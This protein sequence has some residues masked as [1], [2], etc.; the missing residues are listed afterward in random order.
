MKNRGVPS[1]WKGAIILAGLLTGGAALTN[2]GL[3]FR[4]N[5]IFFPEKVAVSE[6]TDGDT[7]NIKW[8]LPVRLVGIDAPNRGEDR[9]A[10]AKKGLEKLIGGRTVWL[11]YDRYPA[12][13]K[14]VRVLAWVWLGCEGN[15][16]F[17]PWNYMHKSNNESNPG[18]TENPEGCKKGKLAQEEMVKMRF[19]LIEVYKDRGELKYEKKLLDN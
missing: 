2:I 4:E 14:Y 18:L 16:K 11:E 19:A 10:E 3:N 7:F 17:L 8:G 12:D 6:V 13:E 5:K 15:P 1:G 9:F